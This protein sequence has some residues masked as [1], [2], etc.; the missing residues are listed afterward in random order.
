MSRLEIK[1]PE[2]YPFKHEMK[3]RKTDIG[4]DH[5]VSFASILDIVFEAHLRFFKF[6]GYE[7]TN[8]HGLSLIFA[9]ATVLYRGELLED[10][11]VKI[12]VTANGFFDKGCDLYF[13]LTKN[14]NQTLV[15]DVKISMLFF[16]YIVRKVATLPPEFKAKIESIAK[17]DSVGLQQNN[18][19]RHTD[20]PL[21]N[22]AHQF[23]INIYKLTSTYPPQEKDHLVMR[24]KKAATSIPLSIV[25]AGRKKEKS[26]ILRAF[27]RTRG[28]LEEIRYYLILSSDLGFSDTSKEIKELEFILDTIKKTLKPILDSE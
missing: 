2:F 6:L 11:V 25:E 1:M 4:K 13:H 12:E 10:D 27:G 14:D 5:H 18:L 28:Y 8:V 7:V 24:M 21:W 15:S 17:L 19:P 26:D 22:S 23:V 16:D 3:I 9:D 20:S